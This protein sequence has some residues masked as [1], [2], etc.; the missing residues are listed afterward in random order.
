MPYQRIA[1]EEAFATP[2]L[3]A[4]YRQMLTNKTIQ[5]PGFLSL[6]G[7]YLNS[8][9]ERATSLRERL[10]DLGQRRLADMDATGIDRQIISL[11]APGTRL[12]LRVAVDYSSRN[13][14][15]EAARLGGL[16]DPPREAFA[17]RLG[18]THGAGRRP[19][20]IC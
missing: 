14:I 17:I 12:H 3:F 8:D 20:W 15:L 19:T 9:S 10:Q 13:A 16:D 2:E 6:W 11:T 7:F 4:L 18:D 1:T 5:D